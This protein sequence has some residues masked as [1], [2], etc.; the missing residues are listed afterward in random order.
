MNK[1]PKTS[2]EIEKSYIKSQ[3]KLFAFLKE[4]LK[5]IIIKGNYLRDKSYNRWFLDKVLGFLGSRIYTTRFSP[6]RGIES[7]SRFIEASIYYDSELEKYVKPNYKEALID[8]ELTQIIDPRTEEPFSFSVHKSDILKQ[9]IKFWGRPDVLKSLSKESVSQSI[10]KN[11]KNV[12]DFMGKIIKD[13]DGGNGKVRIYPV[14]NIMSKG[15]EY[16]YQYIIPG[17]KQD[18]TIKSKALDY[19]PYIPKSPEY[20]E[21]DLSDPESS[22]YIKSIYVLE[23][24]AFI[25]LT[26]MQ[27]KFAFVMKESSGSYDDHEMICAFN[28]EGFLDKNEIYSIDGGNDLRSA[29]NYKNYNIMI[30][31][32]KYPYKKADWFRNIHTYLPLLGDT[33]GSFFTDYLIYLKTSKDN[34][35]TY[36]REHVLFPFAYDLPDNLAS[37]N[38][39]A[40]DFPFIK[41]T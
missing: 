6:S 27:A 8:I 1:Y 2:L 11:I 34:R 26:E 32:V 12:V 40:D 35:A 31:S 9:D 20:F 39:K 30:N 22:D 7:L 18:G 28:R 21:I 16:G 24:I 13:E 29:N 38:Y 10:G 41:S 19:L 3:D 23:H 5:D 33:V 17:I 4:E 14:I 25:M 37:V 36:L 15:V